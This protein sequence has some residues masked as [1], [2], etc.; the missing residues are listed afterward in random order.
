MGRGYEEA[1]TALSAYIVAGRAGQG[2][3]T[4]DDVGRV[5]SLLEIDLGR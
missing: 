3:G 2:S 5:C 4:L 1:T